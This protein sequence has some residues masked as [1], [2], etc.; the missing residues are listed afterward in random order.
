MNNGKKFILAVSAI[1]TVAFIAAAV[2]LVI[3]RYRT[4]AIICS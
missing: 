4:K 1:F 3:R 2:Y